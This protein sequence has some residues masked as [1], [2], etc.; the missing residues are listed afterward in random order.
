MGE[1]DVDDDGLSGM[2]ALMKIRESRLRSCR[3]LC[4]VAASE[5]GG[6]GSVWERDCSDSEK[7][8]SIGERTWRFARGEVG[9]PQGDRGDDIVKLYGGGWEKRVE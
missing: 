8:V 1:L 6:G 3:V 9:R 4:G 7:V 5:Y 2:V